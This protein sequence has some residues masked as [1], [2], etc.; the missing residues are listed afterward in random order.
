MQKNE[1][2][3][4]FPGGKRMDAHY[5]DRVVQADPSVK[6]GGEGSAPEPFEITLTDFKLQGD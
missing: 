4:S 5:G 3:V 6:N 2:T 1:L